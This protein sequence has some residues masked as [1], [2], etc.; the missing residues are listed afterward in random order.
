MLL[1]RLRE[2]ITNI[3]CSVFLDEIMEQWVV[4]MKKFVP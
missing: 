2:Y 3:W 4:G 1:Q